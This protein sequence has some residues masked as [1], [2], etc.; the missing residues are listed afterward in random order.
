[1]H[2]LWSCR[3]SRGNVLKSLLAGL[4]EVRQVCGT[5]SIGVSIVPADRPLAGEACISTQTAFLL[6]TVDSRPVRPRAMRGRRH[7]SAR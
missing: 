1:M 2:R 4:E 6:E 5:K 7:C 3:N